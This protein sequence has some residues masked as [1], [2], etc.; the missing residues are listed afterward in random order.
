MKNIFL[1]IFLLLCVLPN[2]SAQEQIDTVFQNLPKHKNEQ[3]E[4]KRNRFTVMLD[5]PEL[6]FTFGKNKSVKSNWLQSVGVEFDYNFS[7]IISLGLRVSYFND[8]TKSTETDEEYKRQ[9]IN[10]A[11]VCRVNLGK[12]HM[13][14]PFIEASYMLSFGKYDCNFEDNYTKN[15]IRHVISGGVGLKLYASKWFKK[16]KYKNNF[17]IEVRYT[18]ALFLF[19]NSVNVSF[20]ERE[21]MGLSFFYRF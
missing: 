12:N 9:K 15:Y 21:G 10:I 18:K 3:I 11:P 16:T 2:L 1:T 4:Y 5:F 8:H 20:G 19:D 7:E 14:V 17:G 6:Y 13:V